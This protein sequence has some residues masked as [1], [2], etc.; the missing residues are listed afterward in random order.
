MGKSL[1]TSLRTV[2]DDNYV[3][4]C[5][6]SG[7]PR[8]VPVICCKL[9]QKAGRYLLNTKENSLGKQIIVVVNFHNKIGP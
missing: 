6:R 5:S 1:S 2:C 9:C 7:T 4:A 8:I 3:A